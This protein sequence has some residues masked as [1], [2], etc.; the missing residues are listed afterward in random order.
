MN[1]FNERLRI[2]RVQLAHL[3]KEPVANAEAI[4]LLKEEERECLKHVRM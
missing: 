1:V 4:K 2:I 3:E